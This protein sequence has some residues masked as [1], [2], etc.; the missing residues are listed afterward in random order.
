MFGR[1]GT[2]FRGCWI[3]IKIFENNYCNSSI[4]DFKH[5]GIILEEMGREWGAPFLISLLYQLTFMKGALTSDFMT[6][7]VEQLWKTWITA[8]IWGEHSSA[9][10]F[11]YWINMLFSC[12]ISSR[13]RAGIQLRNFFIS[14]A[15]INYLKGSNNVNIQREGRRAEPDVIPKQNV[16]TL[17]LSTYFPQ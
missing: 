8:K 2:R 15:K 12:W 3:Q 1:G 9:E 10:G 14:D 4:S 11:L 17:L 16:L 6:L 7:L 5:C 13:K